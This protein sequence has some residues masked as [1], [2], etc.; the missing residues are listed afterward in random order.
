M[1]RYVRTASNFTTYCIDIDTKSVLGSHIFIATE[2]ERAQI[3][4]ELF[5]FIDDA[6]DG[7]GGFKSFK[8]VD[9]FISDS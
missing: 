3:A 9:H 7:E 5:K 6:Y 2:P 4:D 1:K 8:D